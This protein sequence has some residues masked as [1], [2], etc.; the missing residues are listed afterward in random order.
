MK[1]PS[2]SLWEGQQLLFQTVIAGEGE[3]G[4]TWQ[5]RKQLP[6][7]HAVSSVLF[8][9]SAP[10]PS[11]HLPVRAR[12]SQREGDGNAPHHLLSFAKSPQREGDGIER[13][14]STKLRVECRVTFHDSQP[15]QK[16]SAKLAV[17]Y[18][19]LT[20]PTNREV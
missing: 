12:P 17:S 11:V 20:L 16:R 19:H 18:T 6:R 9:G 3:V 2:P 7:E 10:S 14:P 4:L 1:V 13:I 8:K 5:W 15:R